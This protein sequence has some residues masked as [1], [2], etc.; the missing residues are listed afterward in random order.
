MISSDYTW[1]EADSYIDS[2]GNVF[3]GFVSN[4]D[5]ITLLVNIKQVKRS[6]QLEGDSLRVHYLCPVIDGQFGEVVDHQLDVSIKGK[7]IAIDKWQLLKIS[8]VRA[9]NSWLIDETVNKLQEKYL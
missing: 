8:D 3:V 1:S 4:R 7:P 9:I 2:S 5:A 6:F